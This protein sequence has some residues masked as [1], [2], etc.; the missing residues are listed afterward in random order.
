MTE[1][2]P[3]YTEHWKIARSIEGYSYRSFQLHNIPLNFS[4][5]FSTFHHINSFSEGIHMYFGIEREEGKKKML[6]KIID[7]VEILWTAFLPA[8]K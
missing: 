2:K 8:E 3:K 1:P 4:V 5:K 6:L 7:R